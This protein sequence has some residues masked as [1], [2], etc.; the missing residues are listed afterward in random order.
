VL[1]RE[2]AD[3]VRVTLLCTESGPDV[4]EIVPYQPASSPERPSTSASPVSWP[5]SPTTS[6]RASK[7][8]SATAW[9]ENRAPVGAAPR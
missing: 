9:R 4:V 3:T 1:L 5:R 8:S 7:R 2:G 6:S